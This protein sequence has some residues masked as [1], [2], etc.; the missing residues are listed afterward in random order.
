MGYFVYS[1]GFIVLF[2]TRR[3]KGN[4]QRKRGGKNYRQ[5]SF[6]HL[7]SFLLKNLIIHFMLAR[8]A[9]DNLPPFVL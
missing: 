4:N 6:S 2:A 1:Y 3:G 8:I 9:F 5:K 7:N